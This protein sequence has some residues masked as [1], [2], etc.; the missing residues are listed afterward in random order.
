M[1]SDMAGQ[2]QSGNACCKMWKEKY[3]SLEYKRNAL[4]QAVN[5]LQP[6][7]DRFQAENA[8]LRK[9]Y[10][11]E[12]T[13]ADNEKEGRLK[14]SMARVSLENEISTLKSEISSL[15]Q[16][17]ST[18]ALDRNEEVK[19]LQVRVSEGEKE[20]NR[21]K[22]LLGKEKRR[23][24][25][26]RKNAEGEKKKAA[27][28]LKSIK[29]EKSKA[30]EQRSLAKIEG[31]KAEQYR[32]QLEMLKK[33]AD[34]AKSKLASETLKF[35]QANKKLEAEK[36]KAIKERKRVES[37]MAKVEEQRKLAEANGKKALQEKCRAENLSRQLEEN[38][39]SVEEL[40]KEVLEF[41]SSGN[42]APSGGQ[43]D[44]K[45][46]PVYEKMK[47]KLQ[48]KISNVKVE[49]PKLVLELFKESKKR[50]E[51]GKQKAI[52]E[53]K[54]ADLDL[55]KVEEQAKL[56]EVNWK[57]AME[58]KCRAD[59]LTQQ[60]QADKRTI[61]ELQKKI[62][63][64]LSS[65]KLVEG[66]VVPPHRVINSE[67]SNVKYLKK[68]LKFEKLQ[69]KHAKQVAKFE[70][71]RNHIM[72]QEFG[73]LKMEFD[74]FANHLYISNNSFSP[75]T[76]G[77]DDLEKAWHIAC[78]QRLNMKQQLC[79]LEQ[80]QAHFQSENELLK[81]SCMNMDSSDPVR[82]TLQC[83]APLLPLSGGNFAESISGINSKL[84]PPLGCSNR[85]LLQTSAI[86]S[87]TASFSDG[88][89]MGSQ[90]R[91]AFSVTTSAKLVEE[92]LSVQPTISNLSGEVTKIRCNEKSAEVAENNVIIP[93]RDDVGRVCEH[94]R[95][96]KRVPD[97]VE[98]IEYL[99]SKGKKLHTQ[100]EEKL[101]ILHGMLGRQVGNPL[102]EDRCSTPNLQ[103]IPYTILDGF[104]KRRKS[105]DEVLEKQFCESDERKK[106]EKVVTEVLEDPIDLE[107]MVNFEDVADGDYMK[108]LVLDNAA[109][110]ERYK[111][112]M[113]VP[114]SPTLPNIDFHGAENFDVDNSEALVVEWAYE[115]LSTD[116]ENL[117]PAHSFDVIDVEINSNKLK[118]NVLENSCTL[119]LHK[120]VGPLD[121][122]SENG[123]RSVIQAGKVGFDQTQD[124]GEVLAVSNLTISRDE[125]LKF[126]V[127][128]ELGPSR[129]NIP[130]YCVLFPDMKDCYT[131]S[132]IISAAKNCIARCCLLSQTEWMVPKIL[133]AIK[134]EEN[135]LLAEKVCVFFTLLLLN[136]STAAPR[137]FG[138]F[139]NRDSI[140]CMD[141]FAEHIHAVMS[142]VETRSI[143]T[144]FGFV[145]ELLS[146][147]EDFL[148]YG[149]VTVYD[150]VSSE[151]SIECDSRIDILLD[152]VNIKLL[153]V[154]ASAD[155]L[156]AGSIILASICA[157]I[158]HIA[159]ICETSCNIILRR[160]CDS[161]LVLTILHVFAYLGGQ[162]FFSL[163]DY[164]LMMMVLK[165]IVM[166][167][168]GVHLSVDAAACPSS[169]GKVQLQFHP[170]AKCPFSEGAI[171]IDTSALLLLELLQ[172]IAVLGTTN[173]DVI[174]SFNASNSQVLCDNFNSEQYPSH[175]EVHCVADLNCDASCSLKK[176]EM[177]TSQSDSVDNM[178][179]C[180]LSDVLSLVELVAC[181][182]SWDWTS[183][184]MVPQLLKILES[185]V[186]ENFAAAVVVLLGQLGRLGVDVGGYE[187]K[188]VEN[189]RCNLSAFLSRDAT[190]KAGLTVQ[191]A[192]V[193]ALLGLLPLDFE[194]L[195][196]RNVK[197]QETATQS[198][199]VDYIWKWF[200][201]LSKE[202]QEL[203][204]SLLQTAGAKKK[205][206]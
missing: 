176:C 202:Q 94:I 79:C 164:K 37:E 167:L 81:P 147:I 95:K 97:S 29:A 113:E 204:V 140:L 87:S 16:K 64:L 152:G 15:Q 43:V 34:D 14:E 155:L 129:A 1:A 126:P 80:S 57:K 2:L 66:S 73:R 20:I 115:G 65:R 196:Q 201:L 177:P 145:D 114:L 193:T 22:E 11:E 24:D 158:D 192:T 55:A 109:D 67:H 25:A 61:E 185:C 118:H 75:S 165:S 39:Q 133:L 178:T 98:S 138:S 146:L 172:N 32:L 6:Q 127:E 91:G 188:G 141:S 77:T 184:K 175:E 151:T 198:V 3:A 144:D 5:I 46:N 71:S 53:K 59:Q 100:I 123:S 47:D 157:S 106:T 190:M 69:A 121:Y 206:L 200:S 85:K 93:D 40:Q 23:A 41:V 169:V 17:T 72:Q 132:R 52:D 131:V 76:E 63:E 128:S 117:L 180:H 182:M 148:I 48:F 56:V 191:I 107:T 166:L 58:E 27:E 179:V 51:I 187:D 110:E 36:Q 154:V 142:D 194:T 19:L 33:E 199:L 195:V 122:C 162:K 42:L 153:D 205:E 174:K 8:N 168:E 49:E 120:S 161:S 124:S 125:E 108:L 159:F 10:E 203:S 12:Q 54:R 105:H 163:G 86:N 112:A 78:M 101:S 96:R 60:L 171:S 88:Q 137:K 99:Y 186:L 84:E 38:R 150:N 89:L 30:D 139:L 62:Q 50:F 18:N 92:N 13:R 68:Q 156:V 173:H 4:R 70:K 134:M 116:K 102:G 83:S 9:A 183:I 44:N 104:H 170:C 74:K 82:K 21:L 119:L 136:L 28:E 130:K 35:E 181:N 90:G 143:F 160:A 31:A 103:C 45:L 197:L 189:L 7:I 135:L 149:R 26:E 111:M